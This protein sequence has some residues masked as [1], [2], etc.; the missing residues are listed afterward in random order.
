MLHSSEVVEELNVRMLRDTR[1][2]D[3]C[4][5]L[6]LSDSDVEAYLVGIHSAVPYDD[7]VAVLLDPPQGNL[8]TAGLVAMAR[9]HSEKLTPGQLEELAVRLVSKPWWT[10]SLQEMLDCARGQSLLRLSEFESALEATV[11]LGDTKSDSSLVDRFVACLAHR[12]RGR[13]WQGLGEFV[14]ARHH[15]AISCR[16]AEDHDFSA[17]LSC[18]TNLATLTSSAGALDEALE[19]HRDAGLRATARDRGATHSLLTSH[20]AAAKCAIELKSTDLASEELKEVQ[21]VLDRHEDDAGLDLQRG[22]AHLYAG[23]VAVQR[24]DYDTGM[25]LIQEAQSWF[26]QMAP[27]SV[28]AAL[29]AKVSLAE[30]AMLFG[31][32][33]STFAIIEHLLEEANRLKGQDARSRLLWMQ[34]CLFLTDQ[35]PHRRAFDKLSAQAHLINN[36][37][38]M[39]KTLG[40]LF[41]YALAYLGD[42]EQTFLHQRIGNLRQFLEHES[43]DGLYKTYVTERYAHALELRLEGM[44]RS[45]SMPG[46]ADGDDNGP[47]DSPGN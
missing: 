28:V 5:A 43:Y 3:V 13:A 27:P 18:N 33:R 30:V 17:Q 37:A 1:I 38:V 14:R 31:D 10:P 26:E 39:L 19:L 34:S 40:N 7:A 41:T 32:H 12:V 44:S 21:R 46:P 2:P 9:A 47:Q 29:D 15:L 11:E 16:I 36:P 25:Q 35:P 4:A 20:L 8:A 45:S 6:G 22:Y 42:E 24:E 23:E